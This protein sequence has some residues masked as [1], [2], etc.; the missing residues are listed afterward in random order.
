MGDLIIDKYLLAVK[1]PSAY[2]M[3]LKHK[4]IAAISKTRNAFSV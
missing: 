1:F 4:S 2:I 3:P